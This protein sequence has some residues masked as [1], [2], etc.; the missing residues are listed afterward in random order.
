MIFFTWK[1]V[2]VWE[3]LVHEMVTEIAFE[4]HRSYATESVEFVKH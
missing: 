3:M 1:M 2:M 4:V